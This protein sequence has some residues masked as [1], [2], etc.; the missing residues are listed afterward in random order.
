MERIWRTKVAPSEAAVYALYGAPN[1]CVKLD[2]P[3]STHM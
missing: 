1:A 2:A 3:P